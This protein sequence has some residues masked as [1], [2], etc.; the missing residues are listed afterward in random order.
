MH[1]L[2]TT[3]NDPTDRDGSN[4][5]PS[6]IEQAYNLGLGVREFL[7]SLRLNQAPKRAESPKGSVAA[8]AGRRDC[9]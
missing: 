2:E 4:M 6:V 3:N 8:L 1:S 9:S 5:P 7:F